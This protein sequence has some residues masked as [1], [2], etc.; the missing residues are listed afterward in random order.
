MTPAKPRKNPGDLQLAIL[1]HIWQHREATVA[2]VHRALW[3][4]RQ[5]APTTIATMLTKMEKRGLVTHRTEGRTYI[6]RALVERTEVCFDMVTDVVDRAF[7]G[8]AAD[9]VSM[10]L[11]EGEF[12]PD[13]LD[14]LRSLLAERLAQRDTGDTGAAADDPEGES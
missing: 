13:E 6:Y 8:R 1:D 2:A 3:D 12:D 11:R 10:L 5:L 9:M 7:E 4:E 14:S